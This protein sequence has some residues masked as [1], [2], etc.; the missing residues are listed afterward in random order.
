[1][2]ELKR[3]LFSESIRSQLYL[4]LLFENFR[5]ARITFITKE[6]KD[7]PAEDIF[8]EVAGNYTFIAKFLLKFGSD[9]EHINT[10][11]QQ[12]QQP[13]GNPGGFVRYGRL[14]NCTI[15]LIETSATLTEIIPTGI[16]PLISN[17]HF[18]KFVVIA[19]STSNIAVNL[20]T[21]QY[22]SAVVN[23][24]VLMDSVFDF[25]LA[26]SEISGLL[27]EAD[28]LEGSDEGLKS[29]RFASNLEEGANSY[30]A[31]P[32]ES[33]SDGVLKTVSSN[34]GSE[35]KKATN[36]VAR[37]N[38]LIRILN[39][40]QSIQLF[41]QYGTFAANLVRAESA[42]EV[43]GALESAALPVGSYRIKRQTA[44]NISLNGYVGATG[45]VQ[46]GD[47]NN[48]FVM[49]AWAPVG[50][51]FSFGN[52]KQKKNSSSISIFIPIIDIG[53]LA[54]FRT[55]D[56]STTIQTKIYLNQIFAPGL[57]VSWGLP[58]LPISLSAGY[59]IA[60][61]LQSV[62]TGQTVLSPKNNGRV[63]FTIAVDIPLFNIY[64]A[65]ERGV[66]AVRVG[67]N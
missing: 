4:G 57:F 30:L 35:S 25:N 43:K 18:K 51:A 31:A 52:F 26:K 54:L 53:A 37:I 44:F 27:K 24:A 38:E 56:D 55:S 39:T 40:Q 58:K 63:V 36:I 1:V 33:W 50:P 19:R 59:Q 13:M 46:F 9:L 16:P 45:G 28:V 21:K 23:F 7:F 2:D 67:D 17:A 48:S 66:K 8:V 10:S 65:P 47:P 20:S 5:Q 42:A 41:L 60:P 61:L 11:I 29:S 3:G 15:D 34:T 62:E 32:S 6:G 49:G 64:N 12:L 14:F 22:A